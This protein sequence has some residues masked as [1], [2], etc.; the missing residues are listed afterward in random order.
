MAFLNWNPAFSIGV[1]AFDNEHRGLIQLINDLH[2]NMQA[3]KGRDVLDSILDKLIAYTLE[4][5]EHEEI[6]LKRHGYPQL[7]EHCEQHQRL[8][9]KVGEFR[10]RLSIG[11]HGLIAI[12]MLRFLK[13]WL[14]RHIQQEDK[15][16]AV[17]LNSKGIR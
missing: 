2:S 1:E 17:F 11:Y 8:K 4:H 10:N 3:A 16:Y 14:E 5:F 12:E 7:R 6:M 9:Q 15:A 13:T